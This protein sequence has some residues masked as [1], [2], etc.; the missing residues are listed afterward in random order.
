MNIEYILYKIII[1]LLKTMNLYNL[2]LENLDLVV[3]QDSKVYR[4]TFNTIGEFSNYY[5]ANNFEC[6]SGNMFYIDNLKLKTILN[7]KYINYNITDLI[8]NYKI[9]VKYD[10]TLDVNINK[11]TL[12]N[13]YNTLTKLVS[14]YK[15]SYDYIKKLNLID[16]STY[17]S[18]CYSVKNWSLDKEQFN[19]LFEIFK[20]YNIYTVNVNSIENNE[21]IRI[22]KNILNI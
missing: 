5:V 10:L 16:E 7:N 8:N 6:L 12:N 1:D 11:T 19:K 18:S 14:I 4:K 20:L 2:E 9:Y 21:H 15:S 17:Y 13:L 3:L 22:I